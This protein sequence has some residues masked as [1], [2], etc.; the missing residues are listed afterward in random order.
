MKLKNWSCCFAVLGLSLTLRAQA[1]PHGLAQQARASI[2]K[3]LAW[4]KTQQRPSG[5]WSDE[6]MPAL[7]ALPLWALAASGSSAY[8]AEQE[9]AVVFLLGKQRPDGGIYVPQPGKKGGGLGN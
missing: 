1:L 4:L 3:G 6:D 5:A 8:A 2:G 9:R 7:T